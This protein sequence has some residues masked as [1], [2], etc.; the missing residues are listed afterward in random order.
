M[1]ADKIVHTWCD[2]LLDASLMK[3]MSNAVTISSY[4]NGVVSLN[5]AYSIE[6]SPPTSTGTATDVLH[7]H[8]KSETD[9][10]TN[11]M[12]QFGY[13]LPSVW[14][15][16]I[17]HTTE[18]EAQHNGWCIHLD[19]STNV[20]PD[21]VY[22]MC[23]Y[24]FSDGAWEVV[25]DIDFVWDTH[26]L[27]MVLDGARLC[28]ACALH[29]NHTVAKQTKKPVFVLGFNRV[30][31]GQL[32]CSHTF[33]LHELEMRV[34]DKD[35]QEE[36]TRQNALLDST[37]HTH[38]L[39]SIRT[40]TQLQQPIAILTSDIISNVCREDQTHGILQCTIRGLCQHTERIGV[41]LQ[42]LHAS[43]RSLAPT[44]YATHFV[45]GT[46]ACSMNHLFSTDVDSIEVYLTVDTSPVGVSGVDVDTVNIDITDLQL[47]PIAMQSSVTKLYDDDESESVGFQTIEN[48]KKDVHELWNITNVIQKTDGPSGPVG[49]RGAKGERGEAMKYA[50]LTAT[51]KEEL[52]GQ[53]GLQGQRG[54]AM[55]F[56]D[57]TNEQRAL[58][59]GEKGD[60]GE[61]GRNGETGPVGPIGKAFTF[62]DFTDTQR[63]LLRGERGLRGDKGDALT[64]EEL[65][66]AQKQ[67]LRGERGDRGHKGD[68]GERGERGRV[69]PTGP[70]GAEGKQGP[71]GLPGVPGAKG[72]KGDGGDAGVN[73]KHGRPAIIKTSF[74]ST[75]LL[76]DYVQKS[77]HLVP[78]TYYIIDHPSDEQD[79]GKLFA[80]TG[81]IDIE[82]TVCCSYVENIKAV[83]EEYQ[84]TV[85][86]TVQNDRDEWKV[87]LT[88]QS[89]DISVYHL[90]R[91]LE[92]SI[93]HSGYLVKESIVTEDAI[94]H[95]G[96]LCGVQGS[97]GER[98]E[99]GMAGTSMLGMRLDFIGTEATRLKIHEPEPNS[100]FLQVQPSKTHE[101]GFY[102][103]DEPSRTWKLLQGVDINN[104]FLQWMTQYVDN[105]H[106]ESIPLVLSM[107]STTQKQMESHYISV[108]SELQEYRN[109]NEKWKKYQFEHWKSMGNSQ[110]QQF[111]TQLSEQSH[112]ME[113]VVQQVNTIAEKSTNK[114]E[115]GV[116]RKH[117]D[118][119]NDKLERQY[120][121]LKSSL[122][123]YT[124]RQ[125][126]DKSVFEQEQDV[127][128]S[129]LRDL[130]L[131]TLK[132]LKI[133][134]FLKNAPWS[135]SI[136]VLKHEHDQ[137]VLMHSN[138]VTQQEK[139]NKDT[140]H[141][142]D[143]ECPA[144]LKTFQDE[145]H[146]LT[147]Q[148]TSSGVVV[149]RKF[150][151]WCDQYDK[152]LLDQ[153]TEHTDSVQSLDKKIQTTLDKIKI[154]M[155]SATAKKQYAVKQEILEKCNEL[156]EHM[157]THEQDNKKMTQTIV[158]RVEASE[159]RVEQ[160]LKKQ[161]QN[162]DANVRQ[163][164]ATLQSLFDKKLENTNK[165]TSTKL[166][167]TF[168]VLQNER[169][170]SEEQYTNT[171]GELQTQLTQATTDLSVS[172][173]KLN[174]KLDE[175]K[176]KLMTTFTAQVDRCQTDVHKQIRDAETQHSENVATLQN[177]LRQQHT[178][179]LYDIKG[180]SK[181]ITDF[182]TRVYDDMERKMSTTKTYTDERSREIDQKY[183]N[184]VQSLTN[185]TQSIDAKCSAIDYTLKARMES[186]EEHIQQLFSEGQQQCENMVDKNKKDTLAS[187]ES[188]RED[189]VNQQQHL[190][191]TLNHRHER[192]ETSTQDR[193]KT[194]QEHFDR[195]DGS[196][197]DSKRGHE[198]F[199]QH[200]TKQHSTTIQTIDTLRKEMQHQ[201][202]DMYRK[203]KAENDGL[204]KQLQEVRRDVLSTVQDKHSEL[205]SEMQQTHT[206]K[207]DRMQQQHT[208]HTQQTKHQLQSIRTIVDDICKYIN[209]F[210]QEEQQHRKQHDTTLANVV[211]VLERTFAEMV[212]E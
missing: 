128:Q 206:E 123:D 120:K 144:H 92:S 204:A 22:K 78:N 165:E 205:K 196:L 111:N 127:V 90:R 143:K 24:M 1:Q 126:V 18:T 211:G 68:A 62:D 185:D 175:Q 114:D 42:P 66:D 76:R 201:M 40:A 140:R 75:E 97:Q 167:Q 133:I 192:F 43:R 172:T 2:A 107:F 181:K 91:G 29:N 132:M 130:D 45:D 9:N 52:R 47:V 139:H 151:E 8:Y 195:I 102:L 148:L 124:E 27:P 94:Q 136:K 49:K 65:T 119:Q 173:E 17:V 30:D 32:P 141:Y 100:I 28:T 116:L 208:Q 160:A 101:A 176:Q 163:A 197:L 7:V 155:T 69:G 60:K 168:D 198:A 34:V 15:H 182:E 118:K 48:L 149:D 99:Q 184:A 38:V 171:L 177:E 26:G 179:H 210:V 53:R 104:S 82:L 207:T 19:M 131:S 98:G 169:K 125:T 145:L 86:T 113:S 57:L 23:V 20:A 6:A 58:L 67:V 188:L 137:L 202:H 13:V 88:L 11:T 112:V 209:T 72:D 50:D 203:M 87:L 134:Q 84:A 106:H 83:L 108:R 56:D 46:F 110:Y 180:T 3:V 212:A 178:Q 35:A 200:L 85:R 186:V 162:G 138:F 159:H 14:V 95:I 80:Y 142:I 153:S 152:R 174:L 31:M 63:E 158:K 170:E 166:L 81:E 129:K 199:Q 115:F 156:R 93:S 135:K 54:K 4:A 55:V 61:T 79:H 59:K 96:K 161:A 164:T 39:A 16:T 117:I 189:T 183:S 51:Q 146:K 191:Q 10:D 33:A 77:L 103:F 74:L 89:D 105:P 109:T 21:C 122:A 73:G 12:F 121:S 147:D 64:F 25:Q 41:K 157:Y 194:Q 5:N 150:A 36:A 70:I 193:F 37:A 71:R 187:L 190:Q 154:E 44:L